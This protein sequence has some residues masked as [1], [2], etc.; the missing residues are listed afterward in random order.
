MRNWDEAEEKGNSNCSIEEDFREATRVCASLGI[1]LLEANFVP[2][3]WDDVFTKFLDK[4]KMGATP[5]P[6]LDCNKYIKFSAFLDF[7]ASRGFD[8][9]ATGHY[10][11][12][13][14]RS[15]LGHQPTT[16]MLQGVDNDKDQ[17]YFLAS[18]DPGVFSKVLFPLG[19]LTKAEVRSIAILKACHLH[20]ERVAPVSASLEKEILMISFQITLTQYQ[21]DLL[22]SIQEKPSV[23]VQTY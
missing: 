4:L 19:T 8:K 6:D 7:A 1:Q 11:R 13:A 23:P 3:Y 5:N 14:Q 2:R 12:I 22:I 21:G 15:V 20:R 10:A 17:T 18:I 9:V 16:V